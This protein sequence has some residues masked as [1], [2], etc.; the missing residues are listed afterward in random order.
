VGGANA[1][2]WI[3]GVALFGLIVVVGWNAVRPGERQPPSTAAPAGMAGGAAGGAG[4]GAATTDISNMSPREAADRLYDHVMR[5]ISAGDTASALQFQP[6]AVQA[7][8]RAE[9]LDLDGLFHEALLELMADPAA[10]EATAQRIL[11]AE[12]DHILGLGVAAQAAVAM[13]DSA[14]AKDDYEHLLRVY[15]AQSGRNLVEYDGHRN[16]MAEYRDLAQQY[17]ANH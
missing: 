4:L 10:A 17:V 9:P 16:L 15:D 14:K 7:Y 3:A 2:W 5:S 6:M 13:G 1:P 8:E 11:E 12:P